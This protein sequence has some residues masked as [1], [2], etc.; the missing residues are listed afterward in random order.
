MIFFW[1]KETWIK[2]K[3]EKLQENQN[4]NNNK[5]NIFLVLIGWYNIITNFTPFIYNIIIYNISLINKK[6]NTKYFYSIFDFILVAPTI[7]CIIFNINLNYYL[8]CLIIL[9][10]S[11]LKFKIIDNKLKDYQYQNYF[12][13]SCSYAITSLRKNK[14]FISFV[15]RRNSSTK[16]FL[17]ALNHVNIS[18][19]A[20]CGVTVG[21][22]M[23]QSFLTYKIYQQQSLDSNK[24]LDKQMQMQ[25][26]II[27]QRDR[28]LKYK[29]EKL[30]L[31]REQ[32]ANESEF[33]K[34]IEAIKKQYDDEQKN[35]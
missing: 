16:I 6:I 18:T 3:W 21:C 31:K 12:I 25:R 32:L 34:R 35:K 17:E 26:E 14:Y 30:I 15:F 10:F 5:N 27:E 22:T 7:I 8:P 11:G 2:E 33:L 9:T 23:W 24:A 29:N 1:P 4:F 13:S 19:L 20:V 28:E